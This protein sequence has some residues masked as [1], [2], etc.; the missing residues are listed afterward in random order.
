MDRSDDPSYHGRTLYHGTASRI[1]RYERWSSTLW[2]LV[3][4]VL[5]ALVYDTNI[6]KISFLV[7]THEI[8]DV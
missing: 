2:Y 1:M 6:V 4:W 5:T 3:Q 7:H 8:L